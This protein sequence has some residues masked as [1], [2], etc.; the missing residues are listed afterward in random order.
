MSETRT[1]DEAAELPLSMTD[2]EVAQ[3]IYELT[4]T[5]AQLTELLDE[6]SQE[7][8]GEPPGGPWLWRLLP[9]EDAAALAAELGEWVS[10]LHERYIRYAPSTEYGL[11][12]C[13][14]RHPV[15]V[16][17][18]TALMV[19][20]QAAYSQRARK[21]SAELAYWHE[22]HLW[23]CLRRLNALKLFDHCHKGH[24]ADPSRLAR[25]HSNHTELGEWVASFM[26]EEG[27]VD[28]P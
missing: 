20:H 4:Q 27:N 23:P 18:L 12:A 10:W 13:W 5:V 21:K 8:D 26:T 25:P 28:E 17:E 7:L 15:A 3:A 2:A 16:E 19:A 24:T 22:V 6:I 11:P 1:S 14:F 9:P